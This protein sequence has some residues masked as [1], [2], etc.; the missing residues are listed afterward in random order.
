MRNGK[1]IPLKTIVTVIH[2]KKKRERE[3]PQEFFGFSKLSSSSS[4]FNPA[5]H[6]DDD[7]SFRWARMKFLI[8]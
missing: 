8:A 1:K 6:L 2:R 3:K 5:D 4:S 7:E